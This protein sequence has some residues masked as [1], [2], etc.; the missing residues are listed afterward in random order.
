MAWIHWTEEQLT[1]QAGMEWDGTGF[2]HENSEQFKTY[3]LFISG[4]F[5]LIFLDFS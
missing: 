3:E 1:T 5:H 2:H 4:I